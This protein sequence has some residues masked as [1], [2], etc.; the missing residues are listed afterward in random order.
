M[1]RKRH[2]SVN[3]LYKD[4]DPVGDY[5]PGEGPEDHTFTKALRH[6]LVCRQ[7]AS[8]SSP[9]VALLCKL[10]MTVG[11]VVT[12]LGSLTSTGM[13]FRLL[14]TIIET[15]CQGLII[16]WEDTITKVTSKMKA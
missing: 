14:Q 11:K 1:E 5:A 13:I 4:E 12:E 6:A 15:R 3:I 7:P 10:E 2:A 16:S 8:I 9:K